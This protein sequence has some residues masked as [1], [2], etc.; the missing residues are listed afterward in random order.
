MQL[1]HDVDPP[2]L[3]AL[4]LA[5]KRRP[6]ELAEIVAA[7]E[8]VSNAVP[9]EFKLSDAFFRLSTLGLIGAVEGGY[10]L[11]PAAEKVM[12]GG[13][14]KADKTARA[15]QVKE[16]LADYV[17]EG[18]SAAIALTPEEVGAAMALLVPRRRA[19]EDYAKKDKQAAQ[20]R[21]AAAAR[22]RKS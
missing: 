18:E 1:I 8:L 16:Q 9:S 19:A 10:V 6:A 22:R 14:K 5:S 17:P 15:K 20:W 4:A 2:L 21:Q 13:S 3:L 7:F 12:A 11:T